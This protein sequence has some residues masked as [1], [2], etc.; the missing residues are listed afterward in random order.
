MRVYV[1]IIEPD[2]K[3]RRFPVGEKPVKIGRNSKAQVP[4]KDCLCSGMHAMLYVQDECLFIE[5]LKSKNGIT[6]NGIKIVK[7]RLYLG[8][9][10]MLGD[11]RL[12]VDRTK[13]DPAVIDILSPEGRRNDGEITIELET[14][15]EATKKKIIQ[16]QIQKEKQTEF[17]L[18]SKLYR[19][20]EANDNREEEL[21]NDKSG[22]AL[23]L[24]DYC[25]TFIDVLLAIAVGAG[26]A[27][28][29]RYAK[30]DLFNYVYLFAGVVGGIIFFFW[31][32]RR[33]SGS[34]GEKIMGLD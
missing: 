13:N 27:L 10:V 7:Q 31:N 34:I 25:A 26:F 33:D 16:S 18:K 29:T 32:R 3:A 20:V 17:V 1:N 24:R 30:P 6:L 14:Q 9:Q 11:T 4:V 19:G 22:F 15:R 28:L 5:D 2:G 23:M 8:D 12:Q 21:T